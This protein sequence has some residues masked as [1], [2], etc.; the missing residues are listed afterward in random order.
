MMHFNTYS[1]DPGELV[2]CGESNLVGNNRQGFLG[3]I[4]ICTPPG[5]NLSIAYA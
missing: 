1:D 2:A 5:F 3:W 4:P